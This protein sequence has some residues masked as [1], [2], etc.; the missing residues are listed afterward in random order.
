M[1]EYIP[2]IAVIA[3]LV[4]FAASFIGPWVGERLIDPS[5]ALD[6]NACPTGWDLASAGFDAD[7]KNG[8]DANKN[9]DPYVCV[10]EIPGNGNGNNGAGYN[11]KDNN[12][13]PSS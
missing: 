10:K 13:G 1:A 2:I 7:K 6:E 12:R 11:I 3:L 4:M 9:G 5:V 8:K